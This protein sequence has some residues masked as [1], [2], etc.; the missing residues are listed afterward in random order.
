MPKPKNMVETKPLTLSTTPPV[1]DSLERLVM[2][3]FYGKNPAE[4]AER[5]LA[6]TLLRMDREGLISKQ[7]KA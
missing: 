7:T 5:L 2:T 3:G 4:A 1:I 6:E